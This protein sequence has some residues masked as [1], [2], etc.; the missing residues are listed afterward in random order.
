MP[1]A[2]AKISAHTTS[3][4]RIPD[5]FAA[6][7]RVRPWA[8]VHACNHAR[9]V[10]NVVE[11]QIHVGMRPYLLMLNGSRAMPSD[12]IGQRKTIDNPLSLL[13]G[14]Q[15]VRSWRRHFDENGISLHAQL[16]HAHSFA[17][18]MAA[19]RGGDTVV[20]DVRE[21]IEEQT[22]GA[23]SWLA[24]SFRT[25]EQFALARSSAVVVHSYAMK[26][27]CVSRGVAPAD[28]FV[29]PDPICGGTHDL[30]AL[31]PEMCVARTGKVLVLAKVTPATESGRKHT[32]NSLDLN[33]LF[34]ALSQAVQENDA[35][36]LLLVSPGDLL[37]EISK[38]ARGLNIRDKVI[39]TAEEDQDRAM[40]T[41]EIVIADPVGIGEARG[42][43]ESFALAAM[44]HGK[45]VLAAD[46]AANRDLSPDGR[47][48]LWF[49][50]EPRSLVR[51]L[52]HRMAFLARNA[53][54]RS[55]L[56][57][58]G[59]KYIFDVRS[60]ARIGHMY[61]QVYRHAY[62]RRNKGESS[63]GTSGALIPVEFCT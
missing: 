3:G 46:N 62:A 13:K 37:L 34:L 60:P 10:A 1:V 56:G 14:W 51:D 15:D 40:A 52:A 4:D 9:E 63:Q 22:M 43:D 11:A 2:T 19:I 25:A 23:N 33:N 44:V 53:D 54:F 12:A 42:S 35:I 20:Y 55:A 61:D 57:K 6:T 27:E 39:I 50:P 36:R 58:G 49:S 5:A 7:G 21:W 41:V 47:G 48:L 18:A 32:T 28:V 24:R 17:A 59:Q 16:I 30:D 26:S 38:K 45:A 8:V 31:S 29:V